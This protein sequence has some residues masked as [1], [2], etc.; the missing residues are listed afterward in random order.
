MVH[1]FPYL[2]NIYLLSKYLL[3]HRMTG[4]SSSSPELSLYRPGDIPCLTE[5]LLQPITTHGDIRYSPRKL[6]GRSSKD[7]Q[8]TLSP[9]CWPCSC[10][11]SGLIF[12]WA[13]LDAD[14]RPHVSLP[15]P[16]PC[17]ALGTLRN[18]PTRNSM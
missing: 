14:T 1:S 9:P 3:C 2:I 11:F 5:S 12:R 13:L 15:S 17:R 6:L 7:M 10:S 4:L 8:V 16:V 18:S